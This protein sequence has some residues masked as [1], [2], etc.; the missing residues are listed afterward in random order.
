M[1]IPALG[2]IAKHPELL[3]GIIEERLIG[4]ISSA[5]SMADL[6]ESICL[7][8]GLLNAI[9][10]STLAGLEVIREAFGMRHATADEL[11]HCEPHGLTFT[12]CGT[13]TDRHLCHLKDETTMINWRSIH[14]VL[15]GRARVHQAGSS[16]IE[17]APG[18][19]FVMAPW[20]AHSAE[21][22]ESDED[23][24]LPCTTLVIEAMPAAS[25]DLQIRLRPG[26]SGFVTG[27]AVCADGTDVA[28]RH[29]LGRSIP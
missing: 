11:W 22:I 29:Q 19:V 10:A 20:I 15:D 2:I 13:H 18:D 24:P 5:W 4:T 26:A 9:P 23:G 14:L 3:T 27:I 12:T 1:N 7:V 28:P 16:P 25:S 8:D 21:A 17:V 6:E